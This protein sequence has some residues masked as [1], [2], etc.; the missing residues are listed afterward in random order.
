[1]ND[2][3][4]VGMGYTGQDLASQAENAHGLEPL[5]RE[6]GAQAAASDEVHDQEGH[7]L[8][9]EVDH[10]DAVGVAKA[11]H[12]LRLHLK[13]F[14]ERT[15]RGNRGVEELDCDRTP[16]L[17]PLAT[18]DRA[19][20]SG[21]D[22]CENLVAALDDRADARIGRIGGSRH[23]ASIAEALPQAAPVWCQHSVVAS[24]EAN[25]AEFRQPAGSRSSEGID[26]PSHSFEQV[27]W[28]FPPVSLGDVHAAEGFG[29][30]L[31]PEP[32]HQPP[33][34]HPEECNVRPERVPQLSTKE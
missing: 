29:Q 11:A 23:C 13:T 33:G 31:V 34:A 24:D 25:G 30:R 2:A 14:E 15:L 26:L 6:Q 16:E 27:Q 7:V 19:H 17:H 5:A 9:A 32:R 20:A 28:Y 12:R 22:E 1:M 3:L 10:R 21:G 18:V 4:G 8:D